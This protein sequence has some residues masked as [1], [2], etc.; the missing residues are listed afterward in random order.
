[1]RDH[2]S[3]PASPSS[4]V[5]RAGP[6]RMTRRPTGTAATALRTP[7][8]PQGTPEQEA[9]LTGRASTLTAEIDRLTP[10]ARAT[11]STILLVR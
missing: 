10:P 4:G 6:H 2:G 1:M 7:A 8:D 3:R 5:H 11:S 9:E